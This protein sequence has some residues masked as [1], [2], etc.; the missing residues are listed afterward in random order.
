ME[1]A[2]VS[3]RIG[4]VAFEVGDS[5]AVGGDHDGLVLAQFDGVAGVLD[6][7]RHVGAD[8]HLTV[9][10]TEH[11]RRR[12]AGGD[13]RARLVGVGEHQREVALQP[14]Q[15]GEHGAATKSPA[16]GPWWYCQETR[17]TATSVSVSLA[18]STPV[19]SSSLRS[20]A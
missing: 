12:A 13:D 1:L 3:G 4:V 5:I 9:A 20:T 8:E 15:H 17:W 19:A 14:R 16:V 6:E 7:C 2:V 10:D 11:Q 18:N